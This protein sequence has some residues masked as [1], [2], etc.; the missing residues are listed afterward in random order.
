MP[1]YTWTPATHHQ[2]PHLKLR[3]LDQNHEI[4][5]RG[6]NGDWAIYF[7]ELHGRLNHHF[8]KLPDAKR[9]AEELDRMIKDG[10]DGATLVHKAKKLLA[11]ADHRI[12]LKKEAKADADL[13]EGSAREARILELSCKLSPFK[14]PGTFT[15]YVG[16]GA[17]RTDALKRASK[18][19]SKDQSR[20]PLLCVLIRDK[21]VVATDGHRLISVPTCNGE[22]SPLVWDP[23]DGE[24][25]DW[26][27]PAVK[28]ILSGTHNTSATLDPIRTRKALLLATEMQRALV[29]KG[30]I[31]KVLIRMTQNVQIVIG[32]MAIQVGRRGDMGGA[33]DVV[34]NPSSLKDALAGAS[35]AV[36]FCSDEPLG[37]IRVNR[38]DGERHC[39]MPMRVRP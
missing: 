27:Y 19:A 5:L 26:A 33:F 34:I 4:T 18:F 32:S 6:R 28:N 3:R 31:A 7:R 39:I 30:E 8:G 16:E 23:S 25:V 38:E 10:Q 15:S 11:M 35:D 24:I 21:D 17:S 13:E 36:E 20:G 29:L 1:K 37:V 22:H 9:A 14:D 12:E 2:H